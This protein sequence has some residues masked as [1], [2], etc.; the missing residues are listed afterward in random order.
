MT[1]LGCFALLLVPMPIAFLYYGTRIRAKSK[2]AP[3][4]DLKQDEERRR[5]ADL[6]AGGGAS[7][8]GAESAE[9]EKAQEEE[10][11]RPREAVE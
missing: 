9:T 10:E 3:S 1:L 7:D 2:I 6:E 4:I 8:N 11:E 5:K